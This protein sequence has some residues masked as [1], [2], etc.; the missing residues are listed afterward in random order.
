MQRGLT[1]ASSGVRLSGKRKS[2]HKVVR[3]EE[4]DDEEIDDPEDLK[5]LDF[6]KVL[7][8]IWILTFGAA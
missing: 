3:F 2:S 6:F 5:M 1:G 4:F 8:L 7:C